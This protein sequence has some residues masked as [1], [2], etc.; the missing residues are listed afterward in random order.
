MHIII[1]PNYKI[2]LALITGFKFV[3]SYNCVTEMFCANNAQHK[4]EYYPKEPV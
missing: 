2:R 3:M 4:L 1:S